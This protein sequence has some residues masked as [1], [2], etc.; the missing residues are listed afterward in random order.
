LYPAAYTYLG[1]RKI[2]VRGG[3]LIAEE[4]RYAGRI[5]GRVIRIEPGVGVQV[6]AGRGIVRLTEVQPAGKAIQNAAR[7]VR[8]IRLK[9]E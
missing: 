5:P 6:L 7:L 4:D 3:D 1:P 2:Y 8:S 9:F